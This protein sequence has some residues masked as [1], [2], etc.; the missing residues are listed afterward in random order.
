M[1]DRP[2]LNHVELVYPKGGIDAARAFFETMGFGVGDFGPWLVVLIDP[3]NGDG[4][5]NVLYASEGT[6]AQQKLEAALQKTIDGDA[7]V[8][9]LLDRYHA[10]RQQHPQYTFHF[11]GSVPTHEE[12]EA[13]VARLREANESH[14]LLK[15]H[16]EVV[17][18][19]PGDPYHL[20]NTPQAFV[21]TDL[22]AT[23]PF[24][25]GMT[26]DLQSRAR[27]DTFM[28]DPT[29]MVFPDTSGMV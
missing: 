16:V 2:L 23:G 15:G 17:V 20:G 9:R 24:Y 11:G 8:K 5:N 26:F 1:S 3:E 22:V 12:W 25:L 29:K 10:I 18:L 19:Q 6:P 13:R 21:H 27:G 28:P 4:I 7:E 14:P